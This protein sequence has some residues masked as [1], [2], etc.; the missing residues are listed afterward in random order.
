MPNVDSK[1]WCGS[2]HTV[3][4][5]IL[6]RQAYSPEA[7]DVWALGS[8]L[9]T[10]LCGGFPFSA[11]SPAEVHERI[12]QGRFHSFPQHISRSARDLVSRCLTVDKKQRI[13]VRH[14][15]QHPF[16][17]SDDEEA[18]EGDETDDEVGDCSGEDEWNQFS[19]ESG[20]GCSSECTN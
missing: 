5:E 3:A 13:S 16:F 2:P 8:V 12:K 4:P 19:Q 20:E 10:L 18:D 15:L 7:V 17:W 9:Y 1:E 11:A 6:Q 14:I